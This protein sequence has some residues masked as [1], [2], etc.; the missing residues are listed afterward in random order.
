MISGIVYARISLGIEPCVAST[1]FSFNVFIPP[2][3]L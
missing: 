2:F 1:F 3:Y